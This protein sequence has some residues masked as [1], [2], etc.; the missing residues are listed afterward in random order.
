MIQVMLLFDPV[1]HQNLV[2]LGDVA[3]RRILHTTAPF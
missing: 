3:Q 1:E 2:P